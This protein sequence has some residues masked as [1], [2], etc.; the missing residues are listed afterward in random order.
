M[1][2]GHGGR[3][4]GAGRPRKKDVEFRQSMRDLFE[5]VVTSDA[6]RNVIRTALARAQAGD[7]AARRWIS[8]WVIG[9]V[10]DEVKHDVQ[11][12]LRII[13][14]DGDSGTSN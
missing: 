2:N 7:D 8:D 4:P 5:E 10:P 9:K 1:A 11:G 12:S 13:I 6:F 14:D 3:R